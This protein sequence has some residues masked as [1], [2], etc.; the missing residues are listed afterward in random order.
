MSL[1]ACGQLT[2]NQADEN[3]QLEFEG[4]LKP[5]NPPRPLSLPNCAF[6]FI[7]D[8][9][10]NFKGDVLYFVTVSWQNLANIQLLHTSLPITPEDTHARILSQVFIFMGMRDGVKRE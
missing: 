2:L 10:V 4:R 6:Y 1:I 7:F 5:L 8:Q 3:R 9:M